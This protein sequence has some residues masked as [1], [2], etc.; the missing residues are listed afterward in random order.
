MV[1]RKKKEP[2]VA[3]LMRRGSPWRLARGEGM[4]QQKWILH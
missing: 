2:R 1:E 3:M 4:H